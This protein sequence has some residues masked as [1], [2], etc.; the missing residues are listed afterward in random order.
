M[1]TFRALASERIGLALAR[2]LA[3][4][5][6]LDVLAFKIVK[7]RISD[8]KHCACKIIF[9]AGNRPYA[10][11]AVCIQISPTNLVLDFQSQREMLP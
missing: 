10:A 11:V 2:L 8:N 3:S 9:R 6:V 4:C 7:S 5:K 1:L